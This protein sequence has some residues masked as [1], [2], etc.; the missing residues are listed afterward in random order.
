MQFLYKWVTEGKLSNIRKNQVEELEAFVLA[1]LSDAELRKAAAQMDAQ[2][3]AQTSS[4]ESS[5][6]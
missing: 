1:E 5:D 4:E 2:R 3:L 6:A